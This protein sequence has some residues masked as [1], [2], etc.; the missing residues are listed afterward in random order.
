M[1]LCYELQTSNRRIK[2]SDSVGSKDKFITAGF[3]FMDWQVRFKSSFYT[4]FFHVFKI[5]FL[6]L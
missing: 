6:A 3:F 1:T 5:I 2:V 4:Y